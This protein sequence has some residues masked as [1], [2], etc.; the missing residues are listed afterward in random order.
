[1]FNCFHP[2]K[3]SWLPHSNL[4]SHRFT[5][6]QL[7]QCR[8]HQQ[9]TAKLLICAKKS[10]ILYSLKRSLLPSGRSWPRRNAKHGKLKSK[11]SLIRKRKLPLSASRSAQ[12]LLLPSVRGRSLWRLSI[13]H[14][15]NWES[16]W[17]LASAMTLCLKPSSGYPAASSHKTSIASLGTWRSRLGGRENFI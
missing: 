9:I 13:S 17:T 1:M 4:S 12:C 7:A 14:L 16:S 6:I 8:N 2:P 15:R 3:M 11:N 10:F 5:S